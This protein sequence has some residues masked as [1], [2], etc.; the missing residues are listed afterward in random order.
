MT[1]YPKYLRF[2]LQKFDFIKKAYF[3]PSVISVVLVKGVHE[4]VGNDLILSAGE[5]RQNHVGVAGTGFIYLA[6]TLISP[7]LT[8]LVKFINDEVATHSL[9]YN[10]CSRLKKMLR[11]ASLFFQS[12]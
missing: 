9:E 5:F 11:L 3:Y 2:Q 6:P 10:G 7:R 4:I 1:P 8:L 12:S